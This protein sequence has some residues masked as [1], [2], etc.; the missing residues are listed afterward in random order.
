MHAHYRFCY[1]IYCLALFAITPL[2]AQQEYFFEGLS[3][4]TPIVQS[5][6]TSILQ[7]NKGFI[8]LGT[9]SG[10]ARYDGVSYTLFQQL[11][12]PLTGQ[13]S[14]KIL[15][16]YQTSDGRLWAGTRF[17][18]LFVYDAR[19]ERFLPAAQ[20]LNSSNSLDF[21]SITCLLQDRK[22]LLWIGA[23]QG[24]ACYNPA[25]GQFSTFINY[26]AQEGSLSANY[27]WSLCQSADGSIWIATTN[28]LN[29][30]P[31]DWAARGS[32]PF[33]RHTLQPPNADAATAELHNFLYVVLPDSENPARLWIGSKAGLKRVGFSAGASKTLDVEYF[34]HQPGNAGSLSHDYV[35]ALCEYQSPAGRSLWVGTFNGLNRFDLQ[36]RQFQR[37][38]ADPD[39]PNSL[40]NNRVHFL[41][42]DY[43]GLLWIA[44][45]KGCNKLNFRKGDFRLAKIDCKNKCKRSG[46][47][48]LCGSREQLW[49]GTLGSGLYT[50][51]L[52]EG[53]ADWSRLGELRFP[54]QAGISEFISGTQTDHQGNLWVVTQGSGA[55]CI[56]PGAVPPG[57]GLVRSFTQFTKG[58][59]PK[60]TTDEYLMSVQISSDNAVWLGAWNGGLC[61]IDPVTQQVTRF[62]RIPASD[63]DLCKYPIVSLSESQSPG[64]APILWVG[65]HG[66][67][68]YALQFQSAD[69]SLRLLRHYAKRPGELGSGFVSS[70]FHDSRGCLWV[71]TDAGL[72][73]QP[74]GQ[75]QCIPLR[76]KDGLPHHVVQSVVED[77]AGRLWVSTQNGI[78]CMSSSDGNNW[79]IRAYGSANGLPETFFNAASVH[80]DRGG[81]I[82]FGGNNGV[83]WFDPNRIVNDTISP[84]VSITGLRLF[85][86]PVAVGENEEVD[87]FLPQSLSECRRITFTHRDNVITFEL[88]ALHFADSEN[89]QF[90]YKLEGFQDDWIYLAPGERLAHFTNLPEGDYTLLVKAAN[91]DQAGV[92]QWGSHVA[93]LRIEVLPPW[94][95]SAWAY[96]AYVLLFAGLLYGVRKITLVR[97][98]LQNDIQ[99]ERLEKQKLAELSQLKVSFFTNLSHELKTPLTLIISPLEDLLKKRALE[100]ELHHTLGR[101]HRNAARLLNMIN[102]LL[103][104]RKAESGALKLEAA[105]GDLLPFAREISLAFSE[106]A[107]Q[108]R[109]DYQFE[110]AQAEVR[111]WFDAEQLEKVLFNL[112]SNA[113]KFTPEGGSIRV[114]AGADPACGQAFLRVRDSGVG[115]P[116]A[117]VANI[118]DQFYQVEE[119]L[120]RNKGGAGIGL[121]LAKSIVD[122]HRGAIR[123]ESVP[124]EGST[125]TVWLPLGDAHLS[126]DEKRSWTPDG[127]SLH[128]YTYAEIESAAAATAPGVASRAHAP[129]RATVLLIDDNEDIRAY[130]RENLGQRYHVEEAADGESGLAKALAHPPDCIVCDLAMPGMDGIALTRRLKQEADTNHVPII[131]LTGRNSQL[132]KLEGLETGADDYITKPFNLQL[133]QVRIQNLIEGRRKLRARFS[134]TLSPEP[135][136]VSLPSVDEVFLQ[137]AIALIEAEMAEPEFSVDDLARGLYMNRMQVYR[138]IKAL[139]NLTPNELI[140]NLRLKRAAQLLKTGQFTV[141]EVTYQVGFQDLKYFR[142]RF[143]EMYGVSPSS[144]NSE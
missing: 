116:A 64:Q 76:K 123:V 59:G 19:V 84:R 6:V 82:Y 75:P 9:W 33:E 69:N 89:N 107:Q 47:F 88:A 70:T 124:G 41:L 99:I 90:A 91:P 142:E 132:F 138:K 3:G 113:F 141:A 13:S 101:M 131:L 118:F 48:A 21:S 117:Q 38:E 122:R 93:S 66:N 144:V 86:K 121:A 12:N 14:G 30:L 51:P 134:R 52:R 39:I 104:V 79:S 54:A 10:L 63:L 102:Q 96:L 140:R 29:R 110:S 42:R 98:R 137:K 57:G 139:T 106:L 77:A 46:V 25:N 87:F 49:V 35:S 5:P 80:L 7:D 105:E 60:N 74:A 65:T 16:L 130:L 55:L 83:A 40:N 45:D 125:F 100:G 128:A 4:R 22:G 34:R 23:E 53:R 15:C 58:D 56:P 2:G 17:G 26:P 31:E 114:A 78:A 85:N 62:G 67:G 127:E 111:L 20:A 36:T 108:H 71:A 73:Y 44:T 32:F 129:K 8:W 95:R 61:R 18:G 27:I 112:L 24:L 92:G 43:S 97:A 81:D 11:E 28:G 136:A 103:D 68:L 126:D 1:F 143:R 115:I 120:E 119:H 133:L 50:A 109:I 37:F 135:S 72:D 94:W